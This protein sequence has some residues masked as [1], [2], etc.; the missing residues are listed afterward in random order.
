MVGKLAKTTPELFELPNVVRA[1]EHQLVHALIKCV[2]DGIPSLINSS[3]LRH[4]S[5]V[6]KLEEFLDANSSPPLYL[7]DVCSAIGTA[8]RTLR[9]ACEEHI[10]MGRI[11]YLTLRRMHLV[12]RALVQARFLQDDRNAHRDRSRFLEVGPLLSCPPNAVRRDAFG[13]AASA[14]DE[15]L[16][17]LDRPSSLRRAQ[18][19]SGEV[20]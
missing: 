20:R 11:R 4:R 16:F 13:N 19:T 17:Q 5:I 7:M 15:R 8:E 3:T 1:L 14:P 2:T 10:G 9:A 18:L 6:A 12:H